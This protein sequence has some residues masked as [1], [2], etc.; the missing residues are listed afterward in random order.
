MIIKAVILMASAFLIFNG[1][2]YGFQRKITF[3]PSRE[4]PSLQAADIP[5]FKQFLVKTSDGL[6][7][8]VWYAVAQDNLPTIIYFQGNA[9]NFSDRTYKARKFIDEGYGFLFVG[10]RG[11]N[12]DPGNPTEQ[13]L[14]KDA[15]AALSFLTNKSITSADW[16]FYGESL[17]T[18]VAVQMA[19]IQAQSN[20]PIK[21]LILEAP[22]TSLIDVAKNRYPIVPVNWLLKDR[23]E[24]DKKIRSIG[25]RLLIIHGDQD[26]VIKQQ[27][28]K[29]L[30]DQAKQP[31]SALWVAGGAHS[32]LYEF[33]VFKKISGFIR[34]QS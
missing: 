17:G 23:F 26:K 31:K 12:G 14:Y 15:T 22:F 8:L 16:V 18:G 2:L 19:K 6:E 11:Y 9:G 33:S 7:N 30:Y 10:Y 3:H 5:E 34:A 25:T 29:K 27:F 28:G 32:D 21:A 20:T 13:G 4:R 24:S 1:L